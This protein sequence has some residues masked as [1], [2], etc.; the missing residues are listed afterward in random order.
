MDTKQHL[1]DITFVGESGWVAGYQGLM[2]HTGDGGRTWSKQATKTSQT[3]ETVFFLDADHGW[4]VGWSGTILR[5]SNG[6]KNW[7]EI[8]S[9][10]TWSL[11]SVYFQDAQNGWMVGFAGQIL[12]SRDGG[13]TW[14]AQPSPVK[15]WLTAVCF[16]S[17]HRGWITYD[18]GFLLSEDGGNT[19]KP[20][21][22]G[23]RFFLSK[24][25][26]VSDSLW[27]I[28]QSAMLKQ[29]GGLS[30]KKIDTLVPGGTPVGTGGTP[31][32]GT[33]SVAAPDN[34]RQRTN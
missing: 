13:T 4:S 17:A 33:A 32:R 2:L 5:T 18:D 9:D 12:R 30:W 11:T 8:H 1:M 34:S 3:L 7:E 28:G 26:R 10:A 23:R 31:S 14:Q 22:T 21:S 24:L 19:W 20:V 27:A 16:D 15:A 6:G 29:T 25:F